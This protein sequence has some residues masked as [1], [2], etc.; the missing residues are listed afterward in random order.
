MNPW[1]SLCLSGAALAVLLLLAL[2]WRKPP[3]A[4]AR[5]YHPKP[6]LTANEKEFLLRLQRALPGLHVFPQVAMGALMSAKTAP[7]ESALQA[8]ARFAQKIVDYVICDSQLNVLGLIEL[9][10][11][12]HQRDKDAAR[13]ALTREAGYWTLRYHSHAKPNEARIARDVRRHLA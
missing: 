13:D 6:L 8:R 11:R 5:R 3:P 10:D 9:D 7:G 2:A 12:T 1:M 4:K